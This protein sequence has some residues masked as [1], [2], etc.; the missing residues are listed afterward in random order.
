MIGLTLITDGG[1]KGNPGPTYGSY[2]IYNGEQLIVHMDQ[3]SF[4]LIGTNNEAEYESMIRGV[5][6]VKLL[7]GL[8]VRITIKSDSLLVVNQ[9][10]SVWKVKA[11]NLIVLHRE[12]MRLLRKFEDYQCV[13]VGRDYIVKELGH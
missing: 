3:I 8:D 11:K 12:L 6:R 2:K 10:H 7:A 4:N 1:S 5:T 9:I 13:W